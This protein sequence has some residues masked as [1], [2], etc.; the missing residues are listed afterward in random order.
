MNEQVHVEG[1]EGTALVGMKSVY[2]KIMGITL[3]L[4]WEFE[5]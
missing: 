2:C 3:G 1:F 4:D 5:L